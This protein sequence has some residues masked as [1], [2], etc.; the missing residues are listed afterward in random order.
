MNTKKQKKS[1]NVTE[2]TKKKVA[3]KQLYRCANK[4][5][6][7]VVEDY[8]CPMWSNEKYN[9]NFDESGYDIDHIEEYSIN[10]NNS[11]ENLQALCKSCHSVKTKQFMRF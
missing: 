6:S 7:N 3:G 10:Q 8:D 4:H 2:A 1:R 11:I 5:G 9:G